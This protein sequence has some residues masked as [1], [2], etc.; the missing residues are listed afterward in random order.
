MYIDMSIFITYLLFADK[1]CAVLFS[2]SLFT[3]T[4]DLQISLL[5]KIIQFFIPV[6]LNCLIEIRFEVQNLFY[7]ITECNEVCRKINM[8]QFFNQTKNT[9]VTDCC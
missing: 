8:T 3:W 7:K 6:T 4:I 2:M 9:V 1:C 5:L